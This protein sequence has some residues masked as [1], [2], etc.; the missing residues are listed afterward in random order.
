[1]FGNVYCLCFNLLKDAKEF[2]V[3]LEGNEDIHKIR[4]LVGSTDYQATPSA[5]IQANPYM[6]GLPSNSM[7]ALDLT[8]KIGASKFWRFE[9]PTTKRKRKVTK[10]NMHLQ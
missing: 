5:F 3:F 6:D 2:E 4:L 9:K 7:S 10:S 1:M 8:S